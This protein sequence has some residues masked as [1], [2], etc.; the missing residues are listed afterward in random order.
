MQQSIYSI[1]FGTEVFFRRRRSTWRIFKKTHSST[2]QPLILRYLCIVIIKLFPFCLVDS[3]LTLNVVSGK[4]SLKAT[5]VSVTL[6]SSILYPLCSDR[7]HV[8]DVTWPR[9]WLVFIFGA[10]HVTLSKNG[11]A[12]KTRRFWIVPGGFAEMC[13]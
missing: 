11:D 7:R 1:A 12:V 13:V 10:S 6:Y 5:C 4:R 8:Y 2:A 3:K 9:G